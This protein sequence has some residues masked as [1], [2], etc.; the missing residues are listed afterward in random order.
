MHSTRKLIAKTN[1]VDNS[2]SIQSLVKC[3]EMCTNKDG[4]GNEGLVKP[5][6]SITEKGSKETLVTSAC[7]FMSPHLHFGNPPFQHIIKGA[8]K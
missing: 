3:V 8:C 6:V 2:N 4:D 5:D 1:G 7:N